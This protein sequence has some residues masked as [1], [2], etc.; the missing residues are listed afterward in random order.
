MLFTHPATPHV[1]HFSGAQGG[2][3]VTPAEQSGTTGIRL[4]GIFLPT[5]VEHSCAPE[6]IAYFRPQDVVS[7][8][9]SPTGPGLP[10]T[11][12]HCAFEA[13]AWLAYWRVASLLPLIC[14]RETQ[15]PGTEARLTIPGDKIFLYP[16]DKE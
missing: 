2:F 14:S 3:Q 13:G 6:M 11:L 5:R 9:A 7:Q 12:E 10:A 16:R 4:G 8:P 15:K 1:A